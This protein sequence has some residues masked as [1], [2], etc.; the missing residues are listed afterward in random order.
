[1]RKSTN[2]IDGKF[3]TK[4]SGTSNP[5]GGLDNQKEA[6][7]DTKLMGSQISEP[8]T[9]TLARKAMAYQAGWA[10]PE[11]CTV[12]SESEEDF[13]E[14]IACTCEHIFFIGERKFMGQGPMTMKEG[15]LVCILYG[16]RV[17]FILRPWGEK[18]Y[19][20]GECC[21]LYCYQD[22]RCKVLMRFNRCPGSDEGRSDSD[23]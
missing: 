14:V 12:Y 23:A 7:I 17:P 18:Y 15:D 10:E 2:H 16:G 5:Y 6:F 11:R 22:M 4:D 20:M 19:L 13:I 3:G 8:V 9:E 1:M 21:K